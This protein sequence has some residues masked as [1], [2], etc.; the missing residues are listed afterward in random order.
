VPPTDGT[1]HDAPGLEFPDW[2]KMVSHQTR[3]S[4]AEAIEWNEEMLELFPPKPKR[5]T[6]DAE[7]KCHV[8]FVL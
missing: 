2:S 6:L 3:A 8:E 7:A 4:F 1:L 5:A